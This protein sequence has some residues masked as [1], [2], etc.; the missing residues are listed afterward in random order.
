MNSYSA[1]SFA[2]NYDLSHLSKMLNG[3]IK[4]RTRCCVLPGVASMLA[5]T[6]V[7]APKKQTENKP[8]LRAIDLA[9]KI[10]REKVQEEKTSAPKS[11]LE[12]SV[13]ELRQLSQQLQNVHPN[14]L[15]KH[16]HK[17]IIFQNQELIVINKPYGVP[18][19]GNVVTN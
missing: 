15:A 2:R 16:L 9:Q 1:V 5:R 12:K 14:V 18:V 3:I 6:H 13:F 17:S 4:T 11:P 10:R 8:P 7:T 19:Q